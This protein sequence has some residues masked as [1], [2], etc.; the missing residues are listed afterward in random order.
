M[1]FAFLDAQLGHQDLPI[2][3]DEGFAHLDAEYRDNIYRF[4]KEKSTSRQMIVFT[5]DES[6]A[7]GIS[8]EQVCW[9]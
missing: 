5:F 9:L 6:I 7:E 1:R 4:L 2:L 3:I 8:N